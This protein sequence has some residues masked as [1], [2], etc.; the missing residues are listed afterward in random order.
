MR[1][2][3]A[4]PRYV[5]DFEPENRSGQPAEEK[6]LC[7]FSALSRGSSEEIVEDAA[8]GVAEVGEGVDG[9]FLAR[10]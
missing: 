8:E 2:R 5:P 7:L 10:L 9:F 4:V 3:G 6:V 1:V